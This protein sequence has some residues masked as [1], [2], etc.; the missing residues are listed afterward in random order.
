MCDVTDTFNRK[1]MKV[2]RA[3]EF[4]YSHMIWVPSESWLKKV[5]N[6]FCKYVLKLKFAPIAGS[7]FLFSFKNSK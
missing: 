3:P 4:L 1:G 6:L 2:Y 7:D 5:K